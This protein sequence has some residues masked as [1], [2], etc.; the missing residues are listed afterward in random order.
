MLNG[1]SNV[2]IAV[3]LKAA[4]PIEEILELVVVSSL[5]RTTSL[6]DEQP[7]NKRSGIAS[8]PSGIV[9]LLMLLQSAYA[10]VPRKERFDKL[11]SPVIAEL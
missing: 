10:P 11:S 2:V 3:F 8:N 1:T 4:S 5:G 7:S 9:T 6:K